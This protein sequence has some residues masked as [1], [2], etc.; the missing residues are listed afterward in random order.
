MLYKGVFLNP[1]INYED[2]QNIITMRF[3]LTKENGIIKVTFLSDGSNH[4][5]YKI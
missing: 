3:G 4:Y 2:L 1:D 5:K